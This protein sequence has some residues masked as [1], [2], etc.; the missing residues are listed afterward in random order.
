MSVKYIGLDVH[1][2]TTVAVHN[3]RLNAW[4]GFSIALSRVSLKGVIQMIPRI[5]MTGSAAVILVF[6]I[7]HL[8][9]TFR[10]PK[11]T[12]RDPTL[13]PR[14]EQVSPVLTS[15]TTIWK[16]WIGFNASHSLALIL[17]GLLYGYLALS[18]GNILFDSP[19][20]LAT[21]F[22]ML[23]ALLVLARLYWFSVTFWGIGLSLLC[24]LVSIAFLGLS[25]T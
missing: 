1:Q 19:F 15:E 22:A 9:Y 8:V 7:I 4:P 23:L 2:A 16:A 25:L 17:F 12:P 18:K 13:R 5:L 6:G 11:L 20:L 14:M 24:Y 21:G 10:T 3:F